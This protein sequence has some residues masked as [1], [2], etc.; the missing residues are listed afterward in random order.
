MRRAGEEARGLIAA[1]ADGV[2]TGGHGLEA[3]QTTVMGL[4]ADY[5]ATPD[6]WEPTVALDRLIGAQNAWLAAHNRRRHGGQRAHHADRAGAARPELHAGP[7]RRHARLARARRR[8]CRR[9]AD[10]GPCLRPPRPAQPAD[11]RHRPGRPGARRL[12]CRASCASATASC[13]APTACTARSSRSAARGAGAARQRGAGAARRWCRPRW[14]PARAT[15]PPR[16]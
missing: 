12:R 8:R 6:T 4:L 15:T 7:R 5:F 10:A 3:A 11:A 13:S 16:W 2:S 14:P 1:I 9:A